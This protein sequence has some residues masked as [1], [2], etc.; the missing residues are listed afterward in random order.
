MS[1]PRKFRRLIWDIETSPNV[2]LFWKAGYDLNIDSENILTER[3][4]ICIGYK[5][6]GEKQVYALKWSGEQDDKA[7]LEEFLKVAEEADEMVAHNGDKFDMP[8]FR[9]RCIFHGLQAPQCKTIDTLQWARRKFYFNSNKLN[10]I[11]QFLGLGGKL[12][13]EFGLWRRVLNKDERALNDMIRYCKRDVVLLE[14]VY[15][16]LASQ[17]K[18]KTHIGVL[19]GLE[20]WSCPHCASVKVRRNRTTVTAAGTLQ[21]QMRCGIKNRDKFG[22]HRTYIINDASYKAFLER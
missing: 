21:H 4:I 17:C 8:W 19:Q 13:T 18:P 2:G 12:K 3:K 6:A 10:Y 7:L 14:Q 22:C 1:I 16:A 9:T 5:W 11:A 15:D 20:R